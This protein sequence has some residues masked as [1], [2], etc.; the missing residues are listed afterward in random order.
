MWEKSI[1]W[2]NKAQI[3]TETNQTFGSIHPILYV[4]SDKAIY[5]ALKVFYNKG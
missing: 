2:L 5:D 1:L 3:L 4:R